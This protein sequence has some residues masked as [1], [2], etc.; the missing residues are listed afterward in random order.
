MQK[1][2][3]SKLIDNDL[4]YY[5][6]NCRWVGHD[7]QNQN[8]SNAVRVPFRGELMTRREISEITGLTY[9]EVRWREEKGTLMVDY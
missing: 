3:Q 4:G 8:K 6:E 1:G 9:D 7:I 5:P 2:K